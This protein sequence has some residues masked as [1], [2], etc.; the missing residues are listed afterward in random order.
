MSTM[1]FAFYFT[2]S[3]TSPVAEVCRAAYIPQA[4]AKSF[5]IQ[6]NGQNLC[7]LE[8]YPDKSGGLAYSSGEQLLC[9]E[10]ETIERDLVE[11]LAK[12]GYQEISEQ[13]F[14]RAVEVQFPRWRELQFNRKTKEMFFPA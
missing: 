7:V 6:R 9:E 1:H 13:E 10:S 4:V 11:K 14:M 12:D 2:V 3:G 5:F 8:I